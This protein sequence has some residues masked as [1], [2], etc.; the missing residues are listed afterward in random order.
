MFVKEPHLNLVRVEMNFTNEL[1]NFFQI[2]IKKSMI[3]LP[4][5]WRKEIKKMLNPARREA[6]TKYRKGGKTPTGIK[7]GLA[8]QHNKSSGAINRHHD[9]ATS[10]SKIESVDKDKGEARIENKFGRPMCI[11]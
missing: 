9:S 7:D 8:N 2:D 3:D 4:H 10:G 1:D 11:Y 5:N 6:N